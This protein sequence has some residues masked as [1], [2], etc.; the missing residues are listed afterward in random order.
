M[1][2]YAAHLAA[3]LFLVT[4]LV[5]LGVRKLLTRPGQ[6]AGRPWLVVGLG[7]A[8]LALA[9]GQASWPLWLVLGLLTALWLGDRLLRSTTLTNAVS[10]GL[11]VL[12]RPHVQGSLLLALAPLGGLAW[13]GTLPSGMA[14]DFDKGGEKEDLAR[15]VPLQP[16]RSL[17]FFTDCDS[18][19]RTYEAVPTQAS[20][21]D[22]RDL[23][24]FVVQRAGLDRRV[25]RTGGADYACNCHG[26]TFG[27]G[28]CWIQSEDALM[29]LRE[30]GYHIES[31]P[32]IGDVVAYWD[33][34]NRLAHSGIVVGLSRDGSVLVQSKWSWI[35]LF[36]HPVEGQPYASAWDYYRSERAGNSLRGVLDPAADGQAAQ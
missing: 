22:P 24:A 23:E 18:R 4:G 36:I 30:N 20:H 15:P 8:L 5:V 35:G 1:T 11:G 27:G 31:N 13:L 21:R 6:R 17:Y 2:D 29:I 10:R 16:L 12:R 14:E 25:I 32:R 33:Q 28:K 26:W 19:V 9:Y 7:G 3:A 34:Y